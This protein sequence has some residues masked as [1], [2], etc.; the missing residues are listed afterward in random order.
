MATNTADL[1]LA[2]ASAEPGYMT[3]EFWVAVVV[4]FIGLLTQFGVIHP[5]DE[6]TN[7]IVAL[8][9]LVLPVVFYSISRGI[10]KMGTMG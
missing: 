8:L 6:Q 5:S 9:E 3:T 4:T 10:R 2:K 1:P 7:Q